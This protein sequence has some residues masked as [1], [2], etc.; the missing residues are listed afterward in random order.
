MKIT[1]VHNELIKETAKLLQKK[2]RDETG[3]FIIEG[4]KGINEAIQAGLDIKQ[5]F[6]SEPTEQ[7][8]GYNQIEVTEAVMAKITDTKAPPKIAAVVK[9]P[10]Q[11]LEE[12]K[13]VKKVALFEGIKDPG[14]LGTILRT[15]AAF[16]IDG[17]ILFG[18]TVD[19]YNPKCV[20]ATVGNLWKTKVFEIKDFS[21]LK[22]Y[23]ADFQRLA[24][25]PAN[26]KTIPLN[27]YT[28][29]DKVL[30]MF[31]SEAEGLSAELKAFATDN[32]TIEMSSNV[33][34]L[35]LSISAGI[36]LYNIFVK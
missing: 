8:N 11:N 36:I 10:E 34:S 21:L 35:N 7:Y 30:V 31:G 24:T 23:F 12:L 1:S 2:Y 22:E 20:R 29:K 27:D 32:I 5:I 25:L 18:D 33:E 15:A 4:S 17:V 16:E 6:L 28:P 26:N 9:Q 14:N 13:N 19:I 3:F